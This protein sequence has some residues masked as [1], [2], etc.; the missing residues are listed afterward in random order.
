MD[1]DYDEGLIDEQLS[2]TRKKKSNH[3]GGSLNDLQ[4]DFDK[5]NGDS[6]SNF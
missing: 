3:D 4:I 2:K 5:I 6:S 1:D